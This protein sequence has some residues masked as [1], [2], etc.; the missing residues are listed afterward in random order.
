MS[1]PNWEKVILLSFGL[2]WIETMELAL[3]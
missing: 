3:C 1:I 2:E